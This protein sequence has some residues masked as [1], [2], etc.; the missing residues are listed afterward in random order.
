MFSETPDMTV[1]RQE[2]R[3]LG[4]PTCKPSFVH[5]GS[6]SSTRVIITSRGRR[7]KT[8]GSRDRLRQVVTRVGRL[9]NPRRVGQLITRFFSFQPLP[10]SLTPTH[11]PPVISPRPDSCCHASITG[12]TPVLHMHEVQSDWVAF[13]WKSGIRNESSEIHYSAV[14]IRR[15]IFPNL[16]L[17]PSIGTA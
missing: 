6:L 17:D 7:L 10:A 16:V 15:D 11:P 1:H 9:Y 5:D 14:T 3:G 2:Q 4:P 12:P 13:R 8:S